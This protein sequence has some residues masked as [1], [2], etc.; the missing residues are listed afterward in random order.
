VTVAPDKQ[1]ATADVT[2]EAKVAGESDLFIQEAKFSFQKSQREW[3][4]S[5]VETVRT[6][7]QP[8][9]K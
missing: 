8:Q 3:L 4:I 1:T 2:V 5:R 9:S 7:S 6:V